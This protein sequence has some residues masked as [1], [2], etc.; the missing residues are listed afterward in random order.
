M[1]K[2]TQYVEEVWDKKEREI[3]EVSEKLFAA[4]RKAC[5]TQNQKLFNRVLVMY[6]RNLKKN[7]DIF[8]IFMA[9]KRVLK[10]VGLN[11]DISEESINRI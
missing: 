11:L 8:I 7:H 2:I 10:R 9:V 1:E 3:F 5:L 4:I 6:I